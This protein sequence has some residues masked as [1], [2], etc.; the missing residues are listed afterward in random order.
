M[1]KIFSLFFCFNC[2]VCLSQN[3]ETPRSS[4]EST[5]LNIEEYR[6]LRILVHGGIGFGKV[7]NNSDPNYNLNLDYFE[8]LVN[9]RINNL[10]GIATG[11]GLNDFSGNGFNASGNFY[12]E[13][14][15][16]KIPLLATADYLINENIRAI[17][18]IGFYGK[19]NL[20]DDYRF[21]N[22][23]E[24]D[25]YED[26]SVGFQG[27]FSLVFDFSEILSFGFNFNTQ[28][29]FT[30]VEPNPDRIIKDKQRIESISALG[31]LLLV[32]F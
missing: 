10:F 12:H 11:I 1:K 8:F 7:K 32:K 25:I 29:D 3:D 26:W 23:L 2:L 13:R 17:I 19:T 9:Y 28:T 22:T 18:G 31:I 14:E 16:L 30:N 21:L 24:K 15:E 6:P 27:N 4:A 20:T 5:P